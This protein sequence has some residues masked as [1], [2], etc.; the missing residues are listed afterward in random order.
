MSS[1]LNWL[2][3]VFV[4]AFLLVAVASGYWGVVRVDDLTARGDNPRRILLE[5]RVP[6]G[7]ILDRNGA[8]L[9][10]SVG[11]PGALTLGY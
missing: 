8:V 6:R 4:A 3:V 9:A 7:Q 2:S 5:R 11:A 10:E 1:Q